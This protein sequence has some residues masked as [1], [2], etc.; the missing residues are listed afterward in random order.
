[1]PESERLQMLRQQRA[2]MLEQLALLDRQIALETGAAPPTPAVAPAPAP[3]AAPIAAAGAAARPAS[4]PPISPAA[5]AEADALLAQLT[6]EQK[7]NP[8]L[9]SKTGCWL[10]F[11]GLMIIGCGIVVAV[12]HFFY[13]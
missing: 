12:L 7:K 6:G 13:R 4:L 2:L 10:V 11:F 9:V 1:M 8:S 3:V 5:E